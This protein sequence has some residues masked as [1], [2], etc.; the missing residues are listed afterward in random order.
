MAI[1]R[2]GAHRWAGLSWLPRGPAAG[3]QLDRPRTRRDWQVDG[4]LFSASV[5]LGAVT[6]AY[7]WR[8]QGEIL[9]ALD[10]AFGSVACLALWA[11]RSRPMAVFML[12]LGA[13]FSPLALFAFLVALFNAA[14]R[15]RGARLALC[16]GLTVA[17]S[18]VF[19]L[20]N[21]KA[22]EVVHVAFPAFLLTLVAFAVGLLAR[23]QR[24]LVE[25]LAERAELLEADRQRSV[26]E[27]QEAERRRIAREMHDVLAHRLSLL[28][29]HA[30]ALEFHPDASRNEIVLAASV[31][32]TSAATALDELRH[33]ITVLREDTANGTGGHQPTLDDLPRLLEESR[34][35]GMRLEARVDLPGN[36]P[37][38]LGRA[39]YRVVQEGL[40]NARKHAP[41][42]QVELAV[43]SWEKGGLVVEVISHPAKVGPPP[44][45]PAIEGTGTGLIGLA[46]RVATVGGALEHGTNAG[47]DFVLRATVPG[48]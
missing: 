38:A 14:T 31:I 11:R 25:S 12:S 46:E 17:G 36:V 47:G 16:A 45:C 22:G 26:A 9:D 1:A 40:T 3:P 6:L 32:R 33:I 35:A 8:D 48:P 4:A 5:A 7:L 28:S 39:A 42:S 34:A 21:P 43:T 23:T 27:A 10:V 19:P 20:V 44:A 29:V 37:D 13:A 24:E 2:P 30:G 41:G 18:V 15:L